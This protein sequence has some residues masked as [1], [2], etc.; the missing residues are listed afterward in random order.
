MVVTD[1]GNESVSR[2]LHFSKAFAPMLV[3]EERKT[4]SFNF[5]QP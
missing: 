4:T 3:R 5:V 2:L 1:D